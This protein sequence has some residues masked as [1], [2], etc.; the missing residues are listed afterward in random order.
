MCLLSSQ[1]FV[2][3]VV[4]HWQIRCHTTARKA[5][6]RDSGFPL[7]RAQEL[8]LQVTQATPNNMKSHQW[9]GVLSFHLEF[10][11]TIEE[12]IIMDNNYEETNENNVIDNIDILMTPS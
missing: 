5:Q 7:G 2:P 1:Q 4:K 12:C 6:G 3:D 10:E 9:C 11:I 8:G